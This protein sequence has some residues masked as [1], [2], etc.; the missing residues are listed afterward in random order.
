VT[1]ATLGIARGIYPVARSMSAGAPTMS[2]TRARDV[3]GSTPI[4][5]EGHA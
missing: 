5:K 4:H 2:H 1:T 3:V